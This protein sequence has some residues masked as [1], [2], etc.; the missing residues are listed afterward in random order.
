MHVS[1][2]MLFRATARAAIPASPNR[3]A[4]NLKQ[5]LYNM[6]EG[7]AHAQCTAQVH[8]RQCVVPFEC[9]GECGDANVRNA[10]CCATGAETSMASSNTQRRSPGP[11]H[12]RFKSVILVFPLSMRASAVAPASGATVAPMNRRPRHTDCPNFRETS[13]TSAPVVIES[14]A[15][16][17]HNAIL[18]RIRRLCWRGPQLAPQRSRDCTANA[19]LIERWMADTGSRT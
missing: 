1:A 10:I 15:S 14:R 17:S 12:S 19:C 11:S 6:Y 4:A 9:S 2:R 8:A 13:S 3:L 18:A 16:A 5:C 7:R